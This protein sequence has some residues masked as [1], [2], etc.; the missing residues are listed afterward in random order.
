MNGKKLDFGLFSIYCPISEIFFKFESKKRFLSF[1]DF[2]Y[3]QSWKFLLAQIYD[4]RKNIEVLT[5]L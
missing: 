1:M 3:C 4:L 2:L 5:A